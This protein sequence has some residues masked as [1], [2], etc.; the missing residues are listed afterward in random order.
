MK[1]KIFKLMFCLVVLIGATTHAQ[2]L[3]A[4]EKAYLAERGEIV[5]VANPSHAPFDF[6]RK[7]QVTGMNVELAQWMAAD[8]G[9]KIR[10]E[11]APLDHALEMV[12]NG[13]A[14]VLTSLFQTERLDEE[15]DF[16]QTL[17]IT[18][19]TMYVRSD[20]E[21]IR[22]LASLHN[23]KVA[24]MASGHA[25][26]VL[27]EEGIR[28]RIRFVPTT[29]E[30]V[31]L[32][33]NG[34]VDAIIGNELITEHYM[35]ASGKSALKMVGEPLYTARLCMA[36]REG[37][38]LLLNII[39]KGIL[40][41]QKTG[42]LNRI[43]A[44][45]LGS[46]YARH[47]LPLSY[48]IAIILGSASLVI[49]TIA[50]ILLWNRRLQ[51]KVGER[52]RQYRESEDR[53]RLIFENSPD[54]V[55]V[56]DETGHI[57]SANNRACEFTKMNKQQL[58]SK[59]IHDLVPAEFRLEVDQNMRLWFAG[60]L[61]Q[62]EGVSY[63][64]TGRILPIEMTGVLQKMD[65]RNVLQLHARDITL[66]KDAE[67]KLL[68]AKRM[69]ERSKA[70]AE[71]AREIAENANQAKSEFL[72]NMSHEIRTPL[73]GIV[74]MAQLLSDTPLT[75]EQNGCLDTILQS[76]NGLLNIINHV[77]DISK[78]E[79]GQM[80]VRETII[81]LREMCDS[82]FYRFKPQA[83]RAGLEL[84]CGCRDD[85]PLYVMGDEGL[86]EQ[87]LINL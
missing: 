2:P 56:L 25:L 1:V 78:I 11:T 22:S 85:V 60:E 3:S 49:L 15:F 23:R 70:M 28:A 53:L 75:H 51:H 45:W 55:F 77:L 76:T 80:D 46:E 27:Q 31:D 72:A 5:F 24:I 8:L 86:I 65:G 33:L 61:S 6:L 26:E 44:K 16:S 79:A 34:E 39:N 69:A 38:E 10:I 50:L 29:E 64:A 20:R 36:V 32:L 58:L 63:D 73:N 21:D 17:K 7:K 47:I 71:Q 67:E 30:G 59:R 62:C 54:A 42:T 35:Y 13:E 52:T 48:I 40:H 41:G 37:D 12:R 4:R 84:K 19:V 18:P 74:G 57:L 81:D 87:V 9:F 82:L 83:E 14:D 43:Q 68:E 66:R